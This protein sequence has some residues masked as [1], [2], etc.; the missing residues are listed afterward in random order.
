MADFLP[1]LERVWLCYR[2][3]RRSQRACARGIACSCVDAVRGSLKNKAVLFSFIYSEPHVFSCSCESSTHGKQTS[4]MS[5][6]PPVPSTF[7][8]VSTAPLPSPP[9]RL[10]AWRFSFMFSEIE[11]A[12]LARTDRP[13]ELASECGCV[14]R[15]GTC[16]SFPRLKRHSHQKEQKNNHLGL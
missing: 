5:L 13:S 10:S 15:C 16:F 14:L 9:H 3:M 6:P 4:D 12:C 2:V 8:H 1:S 7:L 11:N